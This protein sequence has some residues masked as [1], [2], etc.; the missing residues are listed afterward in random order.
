MKT[1]T[2]SAMAT[3]K[4]I[5]MRCN[6]TKNLLKR[7]VRGAYCTHPEAVS[8]DHLA[9]IMEN[10]NGIPWECL[11]CGKPCYKLELDK[12]LEKIVEDSRK[13]AFKPLMCYFTREG[14][15]SYIRPGESVSDTKTSNK[16]PVE[17]TESKSTSVK[18]AEESEADTVSGGNARRPRPVPLHRQIR[19]RNSLKGFTEDP[20]KREKLNTRRKSKSKTSSSSGSSEDSKSVS[21]S[22]SR[23]H[24][25][26]NLQQDR[27]QGLRNR[28]GHRKESRREVMEHDDIRK[29]LRRRN[30][31]PK[32]IR[33]EYMGRG[34]YWYHKKRLEEGRR[35]P[36]GMFM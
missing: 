25:L 8:L 10:S 34:G 30:S 6:A 7:P 1:Y 28:D 11:I 32:P 29:T 4:T 20:T 21:R 22:R 27:K 26:E 15:M 14:Q 13:R 31:P 35:P 2:E 3:T 5:D 18:P 33:K 9:E 23:E 16:S 36:P 19:L 24:T 17:S 12:R